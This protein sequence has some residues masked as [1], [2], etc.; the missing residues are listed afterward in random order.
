[1]KLTTVIAA[2]TMLVPVVVPVEAGGPLNTR[3]GIPVR[4]RTT[5]PLV[6]HLDKGKLGGFTAAVAQAIGANSFQ[7]WEDVPSAVI[8]FKR[9]SMSVDVNASN[10]STYLSAL[11]GA[12]FRDGLNPIVFDDDGSLIDAY[13]GAGMKNSVIGFAGSAV[14]ESGPNAGF[15]VEGHAVMNGWMAGTMFNEAEFM[16]TFVH[17]FGHF[18][19]L[20]HT[21]VNAQ[22]A[23][24]GNGADDVYLP[25]MYPTSSDD[26][27][28]LATL[29]PDDIV[30]VSRL[31]PDG[32]FASSTG[33]ISGSVT[34]SDLSP[35][36]G[37]VVVA[38]NVADSLMGQYSTVT[39][40]LQQGTGSYTIS[41][42]P[43]G[44]YWVKI[45]PVR[46]AFT[47][48]SSV[49]PYA[50][51][52][53]GLSFVNPV[54]AEYFNGAGES[55]DP[56]TDTASARV[57]VPV[58]VGAS[59]VANFVANNAAPPGDAAIL[60][61]HGALA[62][63]FRLPSEY[64]DLKYAVRFTPG[65]TARLLKVDFRLNGSPIAV[66]GT[67]SLKV[68]VFS[69]KA[70]S[71][72]GVPNIQQ[73]S[74]VTVPF[75]SL[76]TGVFNDVDL[77]SLNLTMTNGVSFHVV[78]EVVGTAGDTLQFVGDDAANPTSRSSSFYDAGTGA[79]WYN[80][81]DPDNWGAGYNLAVRAYLGDAVLSEGSSGAQT[82]DRTQLQQNYP[83]PFN[84]TTVIP[85]R[86]ARSGIVSLEVRDML[87]RRVATV[88]DL[89]EVQAG[90]HRATFDATGLPSGTYFARLVI[91]GQVQ[92]VR[93]LLLR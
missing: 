20:D 88:L 92:V 71:L 56:M 60:Q 16:S 66:Q 14:A 79:Q 15:Y 58:T 87:G 49:G 76:T 22:F 50:D 41:G 46:T 30:S 45:E 63:V 90:E 1:M 77:T 69:D 81:E 57:G 19:G 10:Y 5:Q 61:Y 12:N 70:G 31:Y 86:L 35:V 48:G 89:R 29:N 80:F 44:T 34:R 7:V 6:Y 83:N 32:S 54:T 38:I 82:P 74:S 51:D 8:A 91:D 47:G 64:D 27:T 67:G 21:Q 72:G 40:Y 85:F 78:F 93:M 28:Q 84:P 25:T 2:V 75:S 53:S 55:G 9:D 43:A 68:S 59:S 18:I 62:Y 26:D 37:A 65:R 52:L 24:N 13:L 3:G 73:G 11:N 4:Y 42:L 36:R 33:T 17:E 23:A 39:D